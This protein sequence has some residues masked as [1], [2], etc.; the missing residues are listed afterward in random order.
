MPCPLC[1]A[2]TDNGEVTYAEWVEFW[3][4]VLAQPEYEEEEVM[5]EIDS[6]IAGGS[7][8]DWNDGRTT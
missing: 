4:N 8:V 3:R 2:R 7:W 1:A 5:E 6:M